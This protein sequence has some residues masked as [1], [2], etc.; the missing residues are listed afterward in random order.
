[1]S[2]VST[3]ALPIVKDFVCSA[4][5]CPHNCCRGW[6]I[7]VDEETEKNY[8]EMPGLFGRHLSFFLTKFRDDTVLKKILGRCPFINSDRLCQ[9]EANG[10]TE[11]MPL[12]CRIYPR[13][14]VQYDDFIEVTLELSCPVAA[15]LFLENPG[16]MSFVDHPYVAPFFAMT[17]EDRGFLSFLLSEREKLLDFVWKE[18]IELSDIWKVLYSYISEVM[19]LIM[20]NRAEEAK[21]VSLNEHYRAFQ[22]SDEKGTFSFFSIKTIDRMILDHIDYGGLFIREHAFSKLIKNYNKLF[23]DMPIATIDNDFH[24]AVL[25]MCEK[26]PGLSKKYRSYFSYNINQLF[27]HAYEDYHILKPFLFSVLYTEL[28]MIFDLTKGSQG[29]QEAETETLYLMESCVRHNPY[30]TQ[31]LLNVMRQEKL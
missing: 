19:S 10:E 13:E 14:G 25:L 30:L 1:M 22:E 24:E 7:P 6:Q 9:F 31:N 26:N 23:K 8:R 5:K 3:R 21:K 16:R 29:S 18:E 27:L 4:D 12:V 28:L 11:L 17:N 2:A 20:R 15:R